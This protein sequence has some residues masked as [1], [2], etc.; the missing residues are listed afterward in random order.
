MWCFEKVLAF[1]ALPTIILRWKYQKWCTLDDVKYFTNNQNSFIQS[2]K[3]NNTNSI[4]TLNYKSLV[5][6]HAFELKTP[7]ILSHYWQKLSPAQIYHER[8]KISK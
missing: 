4:I 7:S 2:S 1:N 8:Q 5:F 6:M 3:S